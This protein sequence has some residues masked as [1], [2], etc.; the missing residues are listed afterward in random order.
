MASYPS[1][2]ILDGVPKIGYHKHLCPF[3]GSLFACLTY[4][5]DP[6]D[7]DFVMGVSGAAFRRFWNRD[8]GGNV[9]LMY[10]SPAAPRRAFEAL[11]YEYEQT[12]STGKSA[13]LD[14]IKPSI[15]AGRPVLA[16]GIIGP[17]ECG[18]VAGYDRD[19]NVLL[20]YSYFQDPSIQGYYERDDWFDRAE[21]GGAGIGC[22]AIGERRARP[23]E[24]ETLPSA[25]EWAIDLARTPRRPGRAAET[26]LSGLAAYTGWADALE[27]DA[28]YLDNAESRQLRAMVHGDQ[29]TMLEE[30][31]SA[32][33]YLRAMADV[34]PEAAEPLR[35]AAALYE[36]VAGEMP[37]IWRWGYE[38]GPEVGQGL[39]DPGLRRDIARHVRLARDREAQAV[40]QLELALAALGG[41]PN[42]LSPFP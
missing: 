22:I 3:L 27:V 41:G 2:A 25:L 16:F 10:L 7:Y 21:F 8:D 18:I 4:L 33:R 19:G 11:G 32:A 38:M 20:G 9:D 12:P 23:T 37:G 34:A 31:N 30:R 26:H 14:A 39:L 28:D 40:D 13:M 36:Q 35:A 1:R 24:R 29:A 6:P 15:A 42:P 17:P 5:G